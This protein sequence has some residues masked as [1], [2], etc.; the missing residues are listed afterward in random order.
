MKCQKSA[1]HAHLKFPEQN[2]TPSNC[3]CYKNS[4]KHK[5]SSF[6]FINDTEKLQT[7]AFKML[8]QH[9]SDIFIRKIIEMINRLSNSWQ[10]ILSIDYSINHC[11]STPVPPN[12]LASVW[13]RADTID[14]LLAKWYLKNPIIHYR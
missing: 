10:L 2:L 8:N 7:L 1:K 3:F 6:I 4:P 9:S 12:M 14:L 5:N 13:Y 11:C